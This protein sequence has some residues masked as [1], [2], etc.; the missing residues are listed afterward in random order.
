[1]GAKSLSFRNHRKCDL[2]GPVGVRD[3]HRCVARVHLTQAPVGRAPALEAPERRL[4]DGGGSI[5]ARGRVGTDL[6]HTWEVVKSAIHGVLVTTVGIDD[7][8]DEAVRERSVSGRESVE[9][10]LL[11]PQRLGH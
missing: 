11:Q 6:T 7:G 8:R 1:M 2:H 9:V 3:V 4:N 5:A 10:Q